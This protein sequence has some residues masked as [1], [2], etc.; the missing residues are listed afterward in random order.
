MVLIILFFFDSQK[1]LKLKFV[2]GE[3][4]QDIIERM[5]ICGN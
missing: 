4:H 3:G 5:E 1:I 2:I